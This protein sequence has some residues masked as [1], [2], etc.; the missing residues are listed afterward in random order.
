LIIDLGKSLI[1]L[2]NLKKLK[3]FKEISCFFK[4]IFIYLH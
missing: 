2:R 4:N 3:Y 1:R